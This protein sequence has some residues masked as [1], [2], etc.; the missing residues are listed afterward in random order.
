MTCNAQSERQ[1]QQAALVSADARYGAERTGR[2]EPVRY[3]CSQPRYWVYF[4]PTWDWRVLD[5]DNYLQFFRDTVARSVR[6]WRPTTPTFA[7]SAIS[8]GKIVMWHG[9]ADQLHQP[10]GTIDYYDAV[11][12]RHRRRLRTHTQEFARLFM[13]PGVAHC[14]GGTGPQPQG[15]STRWSIGS[16]M[17][18]AGNDPCV[19]DDRRRH[20]DAAAVSR[21]RRRPL[22]RQREHEQRGE[23][24]LQ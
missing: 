2:R 6:S 22:Q 23:F 3:R 7:P 16:R 10:L 4:D 17:A 1:G 9:F 5:Y 11:V 15:C 18:G 20:A 21:T 8:G 13:A 14:G 19:E 24:R 12:D